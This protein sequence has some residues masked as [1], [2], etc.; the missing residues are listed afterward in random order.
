MGWLCR[1]FG[2]GCEPE[3]PPDPP[4][5]G[6]RAAACVDAMNSQRDNADLL[7]FEGHECLASQAQQWAQEMERTG[8]MSHDG[9]AQRLRACEFGVGS[10]NV[11]WGYNTGAEVTAGWMASPGHRQNI[12][13]NYSVVGVGVAG[14]YWCAMFGRHI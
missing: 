8:R 11:A 13:G 5:Q 10:E 12:L 9:F 1:W 14:T 2:I 3:I 6:D 4:P 7:P